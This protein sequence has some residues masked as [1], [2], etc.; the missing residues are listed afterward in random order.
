MSESNAYFD[1]FRAAVRTYINTE[2]DDA[3]WT[4]FRELA[5]DGLQEEPVEGSEHWTR[6]ELVDEGIVTEE[7]S[8]KDLLDAFKARTIVKI[9]TIQARPLYFIVEEGIFA[10][11]LTDNKEDMLSLWLTFPSYPPGW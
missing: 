11:A 9:D 7:A 6:D 3:A 8:L 4:Y 2:I 1:Q 10:W 5:R